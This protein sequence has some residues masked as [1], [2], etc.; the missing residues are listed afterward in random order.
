MSESVNKNR[1]LMKINYRTTNRRQKKKRGVFNFI[2]DLIK[3][4]FGIID[5]V[6]AK[7]YNEQIKLV[8]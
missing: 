5:E 3:I 7:Y 8:Q 4:L 2:A 1:R 6:D